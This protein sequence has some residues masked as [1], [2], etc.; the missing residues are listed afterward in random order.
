MT[1]LKAKL[2]AW[3]DKPKKCYC[4]DGSWEMIERDALDM[5]D[6]L[7]PVIEAAKKNFNH[8]T[9]ADLRTALAVEEIKDALAQLEK[10]V[11]NE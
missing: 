4:N 7:W 11:S 8:I 2:E 6:L 1:D 5:L 3:A 10:D 9:Q